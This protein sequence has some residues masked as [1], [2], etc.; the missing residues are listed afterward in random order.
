M[1]A[2]AG[3]ADHVGQRL[4][5]HPVGRGLDRAGQR[6]AAPPHAELDRD[7]RG[8]AAFDQLVDVGEGGR[9]PARRRAVGTGAQDVDQ[10]AELVERVLA[11]RLDRRQR[12][13]G[14]LGLLVD[15]VQ[16]GPGLHVDQGQVVRHDVVEL[17]RDAQLLLAG[18]SS[19]LLRGAPAARR[20]RARAGCAR[21][22]WWSRA[23]AATPRGR[24][25]RRGPADPRCRRPAGATGTTTSPRRSSPTPPR[26]WPVSSVVQNATISEKY[27]GPSG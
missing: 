26:R 21:S 19:R 15:Q 3:M 16:G 9:R 25:P 10:R 24:A 6:R 7:A 2:A 17:A 20:R 13:L 18:P 8:A 12:A 5:G 11:R 14:Q 23:R 27:T 4:L 1:R 22:P